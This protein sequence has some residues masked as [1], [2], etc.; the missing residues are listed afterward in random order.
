MK[1]LFIVPKL[2]YGGAELQMRQL[3]NFGIKYGY[4]IEV[5][6]IETRENIK[7]NYK[8]IQLRKNIVLEGR[9][10][11]EK[12]YKRMKLYLDLRKKITKEQYDYIIFFNVLFLPLIYLLKNK[13]VF[14]VREYNEVYFEKYNKYLR[15]INI[16]TTNN[17]PSYIIMKSKYKNVF[18]QNNYVKNYEKTERELEKENKSYLVVSNI[19]EH[20]NILPVINDFKKLESKGYQLKIAGRISS[21][22]YYNKILKEIKLSNNIEILGSLSYEKLEEEYLK[23]EGV[24]H[25]SKQE[26]TP[27]ALLDAIK[28]KKKFICLSTPENVCLFAETPM[29]M[30]N[31]EKELEKK[32]YEL[33][34]INYSKEINFL[35]EKIK[36]MFSEK[37]IEDFYK[38][39]EKN[40]NEG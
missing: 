35:F 40:I 30:I 34:K 10:K 12:L 28:F 38:I 36:M 27:N 24:I 25:L 1:L 18:L 39:L 26:G 20:K 16:L 7:E 6:D 3:I 4:K 5:I 8:V 9:N 14:S 23:A 13:I 32:I 19:S 21:Q 31:T 37:N 22:S 33:E 11:I 15:K 29:F 2:Y 17:I